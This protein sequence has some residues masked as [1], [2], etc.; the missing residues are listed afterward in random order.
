MEKQEKENCRKCSLGK[1]FVKSKSGVV[2]CS[3]CI[4]TPQKINILG[5]REGYVLLFN[6]GLRVKIKHAE[7]VRLHRIVTGVSSKTI[8][9]M[10][11]DGQSF[12]EVLECV[13]DEF[14]E[15]VKQTKNDLEER[16][17]RIET[18][19]VYKYGEVEGIERNDPREA[20]K[21]KARVILRDAKHLAPI[22]FALMD[23]KPI[24]HIIWKIIRPKFQQ[25]FQTRE[26]M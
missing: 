16:Y 19:A 12:D 14:H 6:T 18:F 10:L 21:V 8:W 24:K 7:Y 15:W 3:N 20:R 5:Q 2:Y 13:P 1:Y 4:V 17:N 11:R 23:N 26:S 22:I 25:P 9:E